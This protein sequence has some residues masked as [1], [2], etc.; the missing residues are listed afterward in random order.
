MQDILKL[1]DD[2]VNKSTITDFKNYLKNLSGHTKWLIC[3]D[4]CIDDKNKANDVATFTVLPYY[5]YLDKIQ[6]EIFDNAPTDIKKTRTIKDTF[7]K[8]HR[9]GLIFHFSF[10]FGKKSNH[11]LKILSKNDII[12]GLEQTISMLER[13]KINTPSNRDYFDLTINKL[14]LLKGEANR[15]SF[16]LKLM[17]NIMVI[18]MIT[19]YIAYLLCKVT[20]IEI[21]GWFSDRDKMI[22]AYNGISTDLFHMNHHGLC[23]RDNIDSRN[24]KLLMAK[25]STEDKKLWY[26]ELNKLPDFISGTLADWDISK[27]DVSKY[28][29]ISMLEGCIADNSNITILKLLYDSNLLVCKRVCVYKEQL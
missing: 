21:I 11:I 28:K 3:S 9:S 4:Y 24:V 5:D 23:E 1:I 6:K 20:N 29:F 19:A 26:D 15:K 18:S 8:Y 14:N 16:N 10:I 13:W 27:N 22:D 17:K 2:T 12:T 7:I 25:P